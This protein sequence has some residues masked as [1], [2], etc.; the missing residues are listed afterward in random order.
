MEGEEEGLGST[1]AKKNDGSRS[2]LDRRP[3]F[4]KPKV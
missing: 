1:Y 2:D 3:P 4:S